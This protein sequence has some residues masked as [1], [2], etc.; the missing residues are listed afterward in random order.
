M[1]I[2]NLEYK[3][4]SPVALLAPFKPGDSSAPVGLVGPIRPVRPGTCCTPGEPAVPVA[5]VFPLALAPGTL[6]V[7]GPADSV[8]PEAPSEPG[9]RAGPTRSS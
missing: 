7:L 2:D 8:V 3:K 9:P 5:P 4:K 6:T 1:K